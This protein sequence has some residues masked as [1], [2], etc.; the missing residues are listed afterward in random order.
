M[1]LSFSSIHQPML[2]GRSPSEFLPLY[3]EC[4]I[5]TND[6]L[7]PCVVSLHS[8]LL[9]R[10]LKAHAPATVPLAQKTSFL[11]ISHRA[12][13]SDIQL[14]LQGLPWLDGHHYSVQFSL[15]PTPS[16]KHTAPTPEH[17]HTHAGSCHSFSLYLFSVCLCWALCLLLGS[18]KLQ[19][20]YTCL[21]FFPLGG[22]LLTFLKVRC[23]LITVLS[24]TAM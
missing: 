14:V 5:S 18:N 6:P 13:G 1:P 16:P 19:Y 17:T 3:F 2:G 21:I 20:Y 9:Q 7:E 10:N 11:P 22:A 24:H 4:L 8:S 12:C 15:L 23:I